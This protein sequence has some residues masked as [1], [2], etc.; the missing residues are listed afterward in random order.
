MLLNSTK[1]HQRITYPAIWFSAASIVLIGCTDD[2]TTQSNQPV[3]NSTDSNYQGG[4]HIGDTDT[5]PPLVRASCDNVVSDGNVILTDNL[6]YAFESSLNVQSTVVKDATDLVFD[7][8][9]VTTDFFGKPLNPITNIDFVYVTLWSQTQSEL[10]EA[11]KTDNLQTGL[12]RGIVS[13]Y[14]DDTYTAMNLLNF[15]ILGEPLLEEEAWQYFDTN[16]PL[17]EYPQNTH[18]FMITAATGTALKKGTRMIKFFNID[19]NATQNRV[20]L[21]NDS[22]TMTYSVDLTTVMPVPVPTGMANINVNWEYMTVNALGNPYIPTQIT[23]ASVVYF[24]EPLWELEKNFLV[25]DELADHRYDAEI[26]SGVSVDL[27]TLTDEMGNPF[28]GID[29]TGVWMVMLFCSKNCANPAPWS[30]TI[31]QAC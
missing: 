28:A 26:L 20:V 2:A 5:I 10:E 15:N 3:Q 18:T 23:L 25:I 14:P 16:N 1:R 22:T 12:N 4:I 19:P 31:L 11:I 8:S 7:W 17:F 21:D 30:I 6:N 13:T 9:G 29:N 27:S 24:Q